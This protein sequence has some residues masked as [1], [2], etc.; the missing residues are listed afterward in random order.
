MH[1]VCRT[2]IA[3]VALL[4]LAA[5]AT[6]AQPQ[7]PASCAPVVAPVCALKDGTKQSYWN[8]CL[9]RRDG[10]L[11]LRIGECPTPRSPG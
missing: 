7:Q 6:R 5:A 10:A 11:V 9:A 3:A 8:E 2:A 1:R 4:L